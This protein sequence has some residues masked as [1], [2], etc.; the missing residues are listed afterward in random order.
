M[1]VDVYAPAAHVALHKWQ[2]NT[3]DGYRLPFLFQHGK[4]VGGS[5]GGAFMRMFKGTPS[6]SSEEWQFPR[7]LAF[8]ASGIR[9]S[10]IVA[11]TAD[12]EIITGISVVFFHL[13]AF[14]LGAATRKHF[15]F[16]FIKYFLEIGN[17]M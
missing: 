12:K 4:P 9:S 6:S 1:V 3:P 7:A 17:V 2:P 10:A 13:L 14:H 8:A 15:V 5:T 16:F 11:I